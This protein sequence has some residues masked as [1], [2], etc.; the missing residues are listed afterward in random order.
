[1]PTPKDI[2]DAGLRAQVENAFSQMRSGKGTDAV[3]TL[4]DAY[5]HLLQMHPEMLDEKV[6][7]RNRQIPRVMRWPALGANLTLE[8]VTDGQ[9]QIEFVRERFSVSEAM[10]YY[11]FLLD[12]ALAKGV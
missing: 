3:R 8:S 2:N 5:L 9:P 6:A 10:T 11:Q 12:E 7:I 1:M 4:A